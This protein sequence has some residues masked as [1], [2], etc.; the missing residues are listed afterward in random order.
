MQ[1]RAASCR[2]GKKVI[3][4]KERKEDRKRSAETSACKEDRRENE[5]DA[6]EGRGERSG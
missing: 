3:G 4:R 2:R 1:E 6:V 5:R